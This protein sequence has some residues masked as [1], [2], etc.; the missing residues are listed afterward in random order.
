[1]VQSHAKNIIKYVVPTMLS[2]VCFFLF[3]IVDGIFIGH[4][5]GANGLGAI[6]LAFPF[7]MVV[8]ALFLL[9]T[10][11]GVTIVAIRLGRG[12]KE[13]AN[14]AFMHAVLIN[15]T[16]A[17]IL[18]ILGVFFHNPICTLLG[19]NDTFHELAT[20][21]LFWYA[22]FIIPSGLSI[23]LQGFCRNDGS[24]VLVTVAVI[25]STLCNIV[26][27][28]LLIFPLQMGLTGAAVATGISQT[29]G[30]LVVLPHYFLK[31]G[32]LCFRRF[33]IQSGLLKKIVVRGLPEGISQLATPVTTLCMNLVL[34][35]QIGDIGINAFSL[36]SY[37]TSFSTA[38]FF[39][40]GEGLQPLFGQSYGAKKEDDL[41]FYFHVGLGINLIGSIF[42]TIL[43]VFIG[44]GVCRL[45]GADEATLQFT[46]K[47]MPHYAWGF[48]VMSVN[49]MISAYLYST[50]RSREAIIINVLRS[51]A[52]NSL[53][54]LALPAIFGAS[55]V[56]Y[57]FGIYEILV[58]IVAVILL[59]NTE[60]NGI[61]Y[62]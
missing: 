12:D 3:T 13:G 57:T 28:W 34:A 58:L 55:V 9:S 45:F 44:G 17:V 49:V 16:F 46:V 25:V 31:K 27:D 35:Q 14:Q 56:W 19:A 32:D 40:T 43:L 23:L 60:R 48:V 51:F 4:G 20:E 36:L 53:V 15:I 21:Y 59:R 10:I 18:C 22:I 39:G 29:I 33:Q 26:G 8:N 30:F 47:S 41:K 42:V 62:R 37:V 38:L 50:K 6:N 7:V 2:N 24:P 1:M 61:I 5:V 52:V 11:G 54:I